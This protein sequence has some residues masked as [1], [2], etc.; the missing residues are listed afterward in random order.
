MSDFKYKLLI[1]TIDDHVEREN[2]E[3]FSY[4]WLYIKHMVNS[5]AKFWRC[6]DETLDAAKAR[7]WSMYEDVSSEEADELGPL[8]VMLEAVARSYAGACPKWGEAHFW[9]EVGFAKARGFTEKQGM[10]H[11]Y[12]WLK[13]EGG[14][15]K[16]YGEPDPRKKKKT[17]KR[18]AKRK[19]RLK[20]VKGGKR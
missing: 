1:K 18:K 4:V 5:Q 19:P 14:Y 10:A 15:E 11:Q 17:T 9:M 3:Y 7:A 2:D 6:E 16:F 12:E 13:D 20:V 8:E